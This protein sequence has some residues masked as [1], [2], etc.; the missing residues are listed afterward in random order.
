MLQVLP[1]LLPVRAIDDGLGI[2]LPEVQAEPQ[3]S[4]LPSKMMVLRHSLKEGSMTPG[5][6]ILSNSSLRTG[7]LCSV[8]PGMTAVSLACHP[9]EE[10]SVPPAQS[11]QVSPL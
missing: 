11:V 2:D 6:N 5:C 4:I 1:M 8:E 7:R 9:S 10:S 3:A